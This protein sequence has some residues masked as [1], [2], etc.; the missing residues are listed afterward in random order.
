MN[1]RDMTE[2]SAH[3]F[4]AAKRSDRF[5]LSSFVNAVVPASELDGEGDEIV[6]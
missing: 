5:M 4:D 1:A 3:F 6:R 2:I